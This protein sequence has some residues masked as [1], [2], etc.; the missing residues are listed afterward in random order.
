M[1]ENA[2]KKPRFCLFSIVFIP[3]KTPSENPAGIPKTNEQLVARNGAME[4]VGGGEKKKRKK[5]KKKREERSRRRKGRDV[6]SG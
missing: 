1:N 5:K 6:G 3:L 2:E 4:M